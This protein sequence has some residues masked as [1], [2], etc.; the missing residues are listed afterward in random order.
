MLQDNNS[1]AACMHHTSMYEREIG[2]LYRIE[3]G[4]R[5]PQATLSRHPH[6]VDDLMIHFV[7]YY[8]TAELRT[9]E[10]T[11]CVIPYTLRYRCQDSRFT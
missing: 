9:A 1:D 2:V 6:R 7:Y 8:L 10:V 5:Q 3:I 11:S 4:V